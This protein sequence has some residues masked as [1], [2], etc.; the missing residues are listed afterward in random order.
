MK[1]AGPTAAHISL[2][3]SYRGILAQVSSS[4]LTSH[5]ALPPQSPALTP[6]IVTSRARQRRR[7]SSPLAPVLAQSASA[8]ATSRSVWISTPSSGSR[9]GRSRSV[10]PRLR[11]AASSLSP[12]LVS[13]THRRSSLGIAKSVSNFAPW[14]RCPGGRIW[15]SLVVIYSYSLVDFYMY[16]FTTLIL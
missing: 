5:A 16:D 11:S 15:Y 8:A 4:V 1:Y 12:R 2:S 14:F 10:G 7:C 6:I 13:P 9:S 3:L